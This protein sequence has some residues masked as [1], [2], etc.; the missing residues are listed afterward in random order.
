MAVPLLGMPPKTLQI[1]SQFRSNSDGAPHC[2]TPGIMKILLD[3]ANHPMA[4]GMLSLIRCA[5]RNGHGFY[6]HLQQQRSMYGHSKHFGCTRRRLRSGSRGC[7]VCNCISAYNKRMV[8]SC[9]W[10]GGPACR[11]GG[12]ANGETHA[13][14]GMRILPCLVHHTARQTPQLW[15]KHR[16]RLR[17]NIIHRS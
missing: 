5:M 6:C 15:F 4:K 1:S 17:D 11:R 14:V 13:F 8:V 12:R 2:D 9:W 3:A 16:F 7:S 10:Q